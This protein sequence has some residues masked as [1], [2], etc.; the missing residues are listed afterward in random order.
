[1]TNINPTDTYILLRDVTCSDDEY[2]YDE[3]G[4]LIEFDRRPVIPAYSLVT[5]IRVEKSA[6]IGATFSSARYHFEDIKTGL[7]G[8]CAYDSE[9]AK[10]TE[11]N[12]ELI[13][14]TKILRQRMDA[15]RKKNNI[16]WDSIEKISYDNP[17]NKKNK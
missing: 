9:I 12:L 8:W 14:Q 10:Y 7:K 3:N 5:N 4:F 15:L 6:G 17:F 13:G 2:I 16:L 1:M 11:N